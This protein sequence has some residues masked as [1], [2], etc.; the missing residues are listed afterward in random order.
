MQVLMTARAV[1]YYLKEEVDKFVKPL[2]TIV[3]CDV[4]SRSDDFDRPEFNYISF[5]IE[6][7]HIPSKRIAAMTPFIIDDDGIICHKDLYEFSSPECFAQLLQ[8]IRN[9]IDRIHESTV[10]AQFES[11]CERSWVRDTKV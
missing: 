7:F 2:D 3:E 6:Y 9:W 10:Q 8:R 4:V 11:C 1:A 5:R